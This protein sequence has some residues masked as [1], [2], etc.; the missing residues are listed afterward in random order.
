MTN[1][2]KG[3]AAFMIATTDSKTSAGHWVR[4]L[5]ALL[6]EHALSHR[7]ATASALHRRSVGVLRQL[8]LRSHRREETTSEPVRTGIGIQ[9]RSMER[10]YFTGSRHSFGK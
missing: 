10:P 6:R 3:N 8:Y 4:M 9:R 1:A 7:A 5:A 2:S